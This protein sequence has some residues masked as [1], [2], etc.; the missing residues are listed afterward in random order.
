MDTQEGLVSRMVSM[1]E[2]MT[3]FIDTTTVQ[4]SGLNTEVKKVI[5]AKNALAASQEQNRMT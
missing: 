4:L 5:D 2:V 3:K 1:E